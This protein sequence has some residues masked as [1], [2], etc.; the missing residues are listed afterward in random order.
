MLLII[1]RYLRSWLHVPTPTEVLWAY[2]ISVSAT[3]VTVGLLVE[4]ADLMDA[5]AAYWT[6]AAVF[7]ALVWS[8]WQ[9]WKR[10]TAQR[11]EYHKRARAL[12]PALYQQTKALVDV[13]RDMARQLKSSDSSYHVSYLVAKQWLHPKVQKQIQALVAH[14]GSFH[15]FRDRTCDH[16]IRVIAKMQTYSASC[17]DLTNEEFIVNIHARSGHAPYMSDMLRDTAN[18]SATLLML[19]R[20]GGDFIFVPDRPSPKRKT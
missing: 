5:M 1:A 19:S 10:D 11:A 12:S 3:A 16:L 4:Q 13:M 7:T 20:H 18:L 17:I 2:L 6:A 8:S 14:N 9:E 15:L